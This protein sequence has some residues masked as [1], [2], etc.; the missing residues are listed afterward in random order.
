M[1]AVAEIADPQP[2]V[3]QA[4]SD[5]TRRALVDRLSAGPLTTS[6]LCERMPMSRFGVMKH[7]GVLERAGLITARRQGRLRL[8]H[9]NVAPLRSLWRGW[10]S[11]H[12]ER[13]ADAI[14][15]FAR[16][17]EEDA[18]IEQVRQK[19]VG[20]VEIA[21]E[22]TIAASVQKVWTALFDRPE[23]WWPAEHR[24]GPPGAKMVLEARIGASL[25]EESGDG[26]GVIWYT[27][28]ALDPRRSVDLVGNLASR[29]GGPAQSLLHIEIVPGASDGTSILKLADS[30][31][32]RIG[33]DLRTSLTEGWQAIIGAG[34]IK[35][36]NKEVAND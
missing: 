32:G 5:P 34:L 7:L 30:V 1:Y 4:L 8:N 26:G 18:V 33:P 23:L 17:I 3:W 28:F 25:R 22:W 13:H 31:H 36:L 35:L 14:D 9:L 2:D 27:V 19:D 6:Q 10:L 15:S 21:L 16:Q 24:A 12:A 11:R 29:Y 20:L